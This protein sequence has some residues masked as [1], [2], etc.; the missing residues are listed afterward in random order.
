MT[1]SSR[2]NAILTEL[3]R[4]AN[5]KNVEGMARYGIVSKNALGLSLTY[6][7]RLKK[8]IGKDHDLALQLWSTGVYEARLLA[9]FIADPD[10]LTKAVMNAWVKDFDNWAI[11]DGVCL[12]LFRR[13]PAAHEMA[14]AWTKR[15]EEFVRRAGF[16]MIATLTVHDKKGPDARFR[17][18]LVRIKRAA[19]DERNY[20]K[21]AVNWALRQIGKRNLAL[22]AE[23]IRTAR[24]IHKIDNPAARWIASDALRELQGPAVRNRL[25]RKKG[26]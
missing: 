2:V 1:V 17:A 12:H 22:N 24:A 3:Y 15:K 25:R 14:A 10:R 6:L 8:N 23:A 7:M 19:A 9:A 5:P 11:C 4:H 26:S 20:V 13:A 21:K 18:H 16:A